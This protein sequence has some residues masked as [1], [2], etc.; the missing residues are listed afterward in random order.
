M[1]VLEARDDGSDGVWIYGVQPGD[2]SACGDTF[3]ETHAEF[4][5]S[6]TAVLYDIADSSSS[7]KEF[8]AAVQAFFDQVN[9]PVATAWWEAVEAGRAAGLAFA[10][11][12]KMPI[13]SADT[14]PSL[15]LGFSVQENTLETGPELAA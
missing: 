4:R 3:G 15:Q 13:G 5:Q 9:K 6:F 2:L 7:E 12:K 14:P 8:Q 10:M 1:A 11:K